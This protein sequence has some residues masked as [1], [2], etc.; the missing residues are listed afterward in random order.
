MKNDRQVSPRSLGTLCL[1]IAGLLVSVAVHA[2]VTAPPNDNYTNRIV[3]TG[4]DISFTGTL[5]G[6]TL[7]GDYITWAEILHPFPGQQLTQ[8]VW[9]QWTANQTT[10]A[11]I[12]IL[13]SQPE[14][15]LDYV[16]VWTVQY[17][18]PV[19]QMQGTWYGGIPISS[20]WPSVFS[21][22]AYA[23]TNYEIQVAGSDSATSTLRIVGTGWPFIVQQ[24]K[25]QTI[26]AG[27]S[28]LFT[29]LASGQK[30]LT[31]QWQFEGTN[32]PGETV[33]MLALDYVTTN[34]AGRYQ[35]WITNSAGVISSDIVDLA[36]TP[37]DTTPVLLAGP[38]SANTFNFTVL[39]ETGRRYRIQSGTNL[40]DWSNESSFPSYF[41]DPVSMS[42]LRS[43]VVDDMGP[44]F[45][46]A[47][48]PTDRR[49][50]RATPFHAA[51]E[52][53][54]NNIKQIRFAQILSCYDSGSSFYLHSVAYVDLWP[55]LK[56]GTLPLCPSN[57]IYDVLWANQNPQ[58]S[59]GIH[60]FEEP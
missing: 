21:F 20:N 15:G 27:D 41:S 16:G 11:F 29:V 32:L 24:P 3:L 1:L 25:S 39:G 34:Q 35:V 46:V 50:F 51:N 14:T 10:T 7:E 54:N 9:W 55:Y 53:C 42:N 31:Y 13:G 23:G 38:L 4:S 18:G 8:S 57:G 60:P 28:V 44:D 17:P 45:L 30:P 19:S 36:V 47:P 48:A 26:T 5:A 43:V 6:A 22:A 40:F 58:C 56:G 59:T 37:T 33:P 49:F 2:Q 12:Q 52:V